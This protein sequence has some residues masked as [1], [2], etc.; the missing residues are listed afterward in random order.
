[1]R[2]FAHGIFTT[3]VSLLTL[4]CLFCL[5]YFSTSA[6]ASTLVF[7]KAPLNIVLPVGK[8]RYVVFP[9]KIAFRMDESYSNKLGVEKANEVIYL[10][11]K[12]AF[13]AHQF[14]I[15]TKTNKVILINISAQQKASDDPINVIYPNM[16]PEN[17]VSGVGELKSVGLADLM[18]Y[19]MQEYYAP[20]RLLH[21]VKGIMTGEALNTNRY[22]LFGSGAISS[23]ALQSFSSGDLTVTAIYLKNNLSM[24]VNL[25]MNMI[26]GRWVA[27][28]FFPQSRLM[29]A[30]SSH[31][32]SML[33]LVSHNDFI[34]TYQGTCGM[35]IASTGAK[36]EES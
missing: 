18:R 4:F 23:V 17:S 30:N 22:P 10:T 1:M 36:E 15:K 21:P 13:K 5:F 16:K 31:D 34:S 35:A 33:F 28:S 12:Q 19:A 29:P 24:P 14:L 32:T 27:A 20:K 7:D 26:C 11:A 25:D 2:G 6:Y 3:F 9:E 8:Q